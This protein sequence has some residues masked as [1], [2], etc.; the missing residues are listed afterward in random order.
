VKKIFI[1]TDFTSKSLELVE[2][3]ILNYPD[4]KLDIVLLAGFRLTESR[5]SIVHL[6][7]KEEIFRQLN[8][9]FKE[10]KRRLLLEYKNNM[11]NIS[12]ELFTGV[13]SY[14]FRNFLELHG[15]E[16]TIIPTCDMLHYQDS[17][18]FD[19]TK[20]LKKN[21]KNVI[22]VPIECSEK[23]RQSQWIFSFSNLFNL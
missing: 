6:D 9:P 21:V 14:A 12:F 10:A 3:A 16:N 11:A 23:G 1:P 15:V 13:N 7:H 20:L 4:T 19:T 22:E 17:K 8:A 5:W 18:W 2:Y